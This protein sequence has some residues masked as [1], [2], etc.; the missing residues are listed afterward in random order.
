MKAAVDAEIGTEVG[1]IEGNKQ[2]NGAAKILSGQLLG[3]GR[4]LLQ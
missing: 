4:H 1:N 2:L 3:L